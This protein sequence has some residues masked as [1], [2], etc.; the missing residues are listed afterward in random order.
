MFISE[1]QIYAHFTVGGRIKAN[2]RGRIKASI[3]VC[4]D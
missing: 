2:V 4:M 1:D 3:N